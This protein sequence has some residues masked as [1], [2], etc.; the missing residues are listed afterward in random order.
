MA[1]NEFADRLKKFRSRF[2]DL[3][4][5]AAVVMNRV[6]TRYLSGFAG[7]FSILAVDGKRAVLF[8]DSRY[9]EAASREAPEGV[10]VRCQPR[11]KAL[12]YYRDF[13][14]PLKGKRVGHE[15]S[16]TVA[17][18]DRLKKYARGAKWTPA[19]SAILKLRAVKSESELKSVRKAAKLADAM[20]HLAVETARAGMPES[21]LSKAIRRASEDLGGTGESFENI[22]ASGPNSSSPHHTPGKRK[23]KSGDPVTVDLGGVVEGYC[24]DLTR[25]FAIGKASKKFTEIYGVCLEANE[26]AIAGIR[27]GMTG[28]EADALARNAIEKAGFGEYFGHSLGHGVGIEIHEQPRLA[29]TSADILEPGMVITIEPGIYI[30]GVGGVRIEDLAVVTAKGVAVLSKTPKNLLVV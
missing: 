16:I 9:A 11:E 30:P 28:K 14:A 27:P 3:K 25:T 21:E 23:L 13:F 1:A 12:E 6:N 24:S 29:T 22:V 7:S 20:M 4:I 15:S 2:A 5:D 26:A 17:E 10:E 19:E 18:L 8:T